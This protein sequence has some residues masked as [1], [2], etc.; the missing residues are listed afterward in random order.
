MQGG[1][2]CELPIYFVPAKL[3]NTVLYWQRKRGKI[4]GKL[5]LLPLDA[6]DV[7]DLAVDGIVG[8]D[9]TGSRDGAGQADLGVD[10]EWECGSTG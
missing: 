4:L 6:D 7:A 8:Q 9:A 2:L 5:T 10:I 3:M 1:E